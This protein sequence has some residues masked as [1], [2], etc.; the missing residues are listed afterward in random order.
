MYK[1]SLVFLLLIVSCSKKDVAVD[2][3][4]QKQELDSLSRLTKTIDYSDSQLK[5]LMPIF[6]EK[7]EALNS[8]SLKNKYLTEVS[9]LYFNIG[10]IHNYFE[11]CKKR[12]IQAEKTQDTTA[13]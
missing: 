2:L 5:R 6:L 13:L 3:K 4:K 1:I 10:D 11:I 8:S 7:T 12:R 9:N